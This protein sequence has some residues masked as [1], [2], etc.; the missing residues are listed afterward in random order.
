[1]SKQH[2]QFILPLSQIKGLRSHEWYATGHSKVRMCACV[3]VYVRVHACMRARVLM[4]VCLGEC[5]WIQVRVRVAIWIGANECLWIKVSMAMWIKAN[6][7]KLWASLIWCSCSFSPRQHLDAKM[8]LAL[9][10]W[11]LTEASRMQG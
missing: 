3:C 2:Q 5:L 7:C 8:R 10:G 11:H 9:E 6:A 1:M 4:C